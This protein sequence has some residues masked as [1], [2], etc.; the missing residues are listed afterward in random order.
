ME[1]VTGL[2]RPGSRAFQMTLT[3]LTYYFHIDVHLVN[4]R[5]CSSNPMVYTSRPSTCYIYIKMFGMVAA[6]AS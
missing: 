5:I 6:V 2:A 4:R 3:L 1:V